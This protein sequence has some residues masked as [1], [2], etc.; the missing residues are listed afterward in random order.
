MK[1]SGPSSLI[2]LEKPILP[3]FLHSPK[4]PTNSY[5]D[6]IGNQ[7]YF[8]T[9]QDFNEYLLKKEQELKSAYKAEK[10]N[11][12]SNE[13]SDKENEAEMPSAFFKTEVGG[14]GKLTKKDLMKLAISFEQHKK[15]FNLDQPNPFVTPKQKRHHKSKKKM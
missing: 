7:Q 14:G 13:N 2:S 3:T 5:K 10:R 12:D 6:R 11:S 4:L 15:R 9:H 1:A 8:Y